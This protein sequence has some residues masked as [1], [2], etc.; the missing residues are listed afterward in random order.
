MIVR[1]LL[2]APALLLAVACASTTAASSLALG[3]AMP[4]APATTLRD[5][6]IG[7]EPDGPV[8]VSGTVVD[9]C[10]KKGCWFVLSDGGQEMRVSV[11]QCGE[12]AV[13]IESIGRPVTAW[14]TAGRTT[15]DEATARHY[16]EE[17]GRDAT[18]IHGEQSVLAMTAR[19]I[20]IELP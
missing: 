8:L 16:A 7:L 9:V 19:G 3:D 5:L 1:H 12:V 13:P 15:I 6:A 4:V 10:R 11:K 2:L 17:S 18:E 14:G 20:R